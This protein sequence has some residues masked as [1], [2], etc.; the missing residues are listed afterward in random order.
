MISS[1]PGPLLTMVIG[2][3]ICSSMNSYILS[4]VLRQF[5]EFADTADITLPTG[6]L[7][8][9]GLCLFQLVGNRKSVVTSPSIS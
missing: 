7:L 1:L 4:A 8:Q 2:K 9:Y 5:I 3:P 6:E